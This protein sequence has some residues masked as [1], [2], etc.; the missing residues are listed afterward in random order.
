MIQRYVNA[1]LKEPSEDHESDC[2]SNDQNEA[3]VVELLAGQ[4]RQLPTA[5]CH[6]YQLDDRAKDQLVNYFQQHVQLAPARTI[7]EK[8]IKPLNAMNDELLKVILNLRLIRSALSIRD[9]LNDDEW[10]PFANH[11]VIG[12]NQQHQQ[13]AIL[14]TNG[15]AAY[16]KYVEL[17]GA[18]KELLVKALTICKQFLNDHQAFVIDYDFKAELISTTGQCIQQL[19]KLPVEESDI[20]EGPA[21][22]PSPLEIELSEMK[23]ENEMM[24]KQLR[25]SSEV[26]FMFKVDKFSELFKYG[27]K[28]ISDPFY[29]RNIQWVIVAVSRVEYPKQLELFLELY[30][31]ESMF[32]GQPMA[33]NASATFEILHSLNSQIDMVCFFNHSYTQPG[34]GFGGSVAL[35]D[36]LMAKKFTKNDVLNI[37]F[38]LVIN[39][40]T[41]FPV[42]HFPELVSLY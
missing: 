8:H 6:L 40:L 26:A 32:N 31:D 22:S 35:Y 15:K 39:E 41:F 3:V 34:E 33:C 20:V 7:D 30:R 5:K 4:F 25:F 10:P 21:T 11:N 27:A 28:L 14:I 12:H 29:C 24:C 13:P 38:N 19:M 23:I 1:L 9:D 16:T 2:E 37:K 42:P 36:D 18:L 17:D